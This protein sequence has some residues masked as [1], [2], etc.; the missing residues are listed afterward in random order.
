M[1]PRTSAEL[2]AFGPYPVGVQTIENFIDTSRPTPPNGTY[3]GTTHRKLV[4]EVWYPA[5]MW[6]R[7]A[8][9][10]AS[11]APYPVVIHSHGLRGV[12]TGE[13]YIA[14]HLASRGYVVVAPDYPLSN[15]FAPGGPTRADLPNQPGDWSFVLDSILASAEFGASVDP[16]RV[17]ASGFS[18]GGL[19]TLL[20]TYHRD[21]RDPRIRAALAMAAPGGCMFT[22]TFFQTTPTPLLLLHGDSDVLAPIRYNAKRSYHFAGPPKQLVRLRNGSHSGFSGFALGFDQSQHFDAI[23]CTGLADIFDDFDPANPFPGLGGVEVGIHPNPS[24]CRKPCSDPVPADPAMLAAQHHYLT[25]IVTAGF[26][27]GELRDDAAARCY[28]QRSLRREYPDDV[29]VRTRSGR[30]LP[31]FSSGVLGF[32]SPGRCGE[33]APLPFPELGAQHVAQELAGRIAR[34]LVAHDQTARSLIARQARLARSLDRLECGAPRRRI[35]AGVAIEHHERN[36]RLAAHVIG[37]AD[38]AGVAHAGER[39]Y[40]FYFIEFPNPPMALPLPRAGIKLTQY[41]P[42]SP[43]PSYVEFSYLEPWGRTVWHDASSRS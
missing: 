40:S 24:R 37:S 9:V 36:R 38:H 26:L 22:P 34:Q 39:R 2:E 20:A 6:G 1:T 33:V 7:N 3:A 11:G 15:L 5:Q 35:A 4:T 8:D 31:F 21:L 42:R 43:L 27:D 41:R 28:L 10:D 14:E 32:A 12:R 19:T 13:Q 29:R 23:G 30:R 25:K 16:T 18:L 17:G